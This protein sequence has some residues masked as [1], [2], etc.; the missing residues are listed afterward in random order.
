MTFVHPQGHGGNTRTFSLK[1]INSLVVCVCMFVS[2]YVFMWVHI[3]VYAYTYE[4]QR[5]MLGVLI[6]PNPCV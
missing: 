3:I 4:A 5:L 1:N 2:V 6:V